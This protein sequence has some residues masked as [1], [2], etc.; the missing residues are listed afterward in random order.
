M[1]RSRS[2]ASEVAKRARENGF[3]VLV[4]GQYVA[5]IRGGEEIFHTSSWTR[6]ADYL[7]GYEMGLEARK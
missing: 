7:D 3:G 4:I 1:V 6:V 5:L 2:D